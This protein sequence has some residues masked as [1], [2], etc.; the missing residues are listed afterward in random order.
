MLT[1][2]RLIIRPLEEKDEAD[3]VKLLTNEVIKRTY[4]LPDFTTKEQVVALHQRLR[5]F[6]HSD[7]HYVRGMDN[8][9]ELLGFVN[10]VEMTQD[11]I[12]LGYVVHPEFHNQGY[13]TEM[14]AAVIEEL[15]QRGFR[16][17]CAGAFEENLASQ[18]VM[19]KCGMKRIEKT[20]ELVYRGKLQHCVYYAKNAE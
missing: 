1:T 7:G 6:S 9:K 8:G 16:E 3:M 19:E 12:E 4:M 10:E 13:A 2:K 17:V 18:R 5:E 20:D 14:L 11:S 15:F